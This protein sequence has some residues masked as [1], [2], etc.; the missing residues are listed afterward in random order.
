MASNKGVSSRGF[1]VKNP[2][3]ASGVKFVKSPTNPLPGHRSN[4]SMTGNSKPSQASQ[5]SYAGR[6]ATTSSGYASS[7]GREFGSFIGSV[8]VSKLRHTKKPETKN[9]IKP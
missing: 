4:E 5:I 9:Q 1:N 8:N 3:G 7:R 2:Q 6:A